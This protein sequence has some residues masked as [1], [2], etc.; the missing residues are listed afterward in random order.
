MEASIAALL[1]VLGA[2]YEFPIELSA[3]CS[4]ISLP[5]KIFSFGVA[6]LLSGQIPDFRKAAMTCSRRNS[7]IMT[8]EEPFS[9]GE[10]FAS[11]FLCNTFLQLQ[12]KKL[13]KRFVILN[14]YVIY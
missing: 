4:S 7:L 1:P 13:K 5:Y 10:K 8:L 6:S 11:D 14:N 12:L 2:S 3:N 9:K